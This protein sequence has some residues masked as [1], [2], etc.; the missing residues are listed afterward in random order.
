MDS[1]LATWTEPEG[2][3][4]QD[5]ADDAGPGSA[6]MNPF[7]TI[8][9]PPPTLTAQQPELQHGDALLPIVVLVA[10]LAAVGC[11]LGGMR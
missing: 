5:G 4:V 10:G 8:G 7:S 3:Q 9:A 1:E 6:V 11:M 2:V